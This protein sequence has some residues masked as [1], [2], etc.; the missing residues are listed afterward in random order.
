MSDVLTKRCC[1]CGETL[2]MLG[3]PHVILRATRIIPTE[4]TKK[5]EYLRYYHEQCFQRD[6]LRAALP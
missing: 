2:D 1:E 5:L 3:D 4:Y 6:R